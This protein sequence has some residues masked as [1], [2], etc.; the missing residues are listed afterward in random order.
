MPGCRH[1]GWLDV[2]PPDDDDGNATEGGTFTLSVSD[3]LDQLVEGLPRPEVQ[4]PSLIFL[5]GGRRKTAALQGLLHG[6]PARARRPRDADLELVLDPHSAF[7]DRPLMYVDCDHL[8]SRGWRRRPS[9]HGCHRTWE[10]R[11]LSGGVGPGSPVEPC[12]TTRLAARLVAPL[13]DVVAVFLGDFPGPECAFDR[14]LTWISCGRPSTLHRSVRPRLLLI[15][16]RAVGRGLS[17]GAILRRLSR[18]SLSSF[19]DVFS[20]VIPLTVPEDEGLGTVAK[21]LQLKDTVLNLSDQ[22]QQT[23]W[24]ARACFSARH[25][26]AFFHRNVDHCQSKPGGPFDFIHA[27][28]LHDAVPDHLAS[29]LEDFLSGFR[30]TSTVV[31]LAL[32][33]LATSLLLNHYCPETHVFDPDDVFVT[34]YSEAC[35]AALGRTA[36]RRAEGGLSPQLLLELTREKFRAVFSNWQAGGDDLNSLHRKYLRRLKGHWHAGPK[37]TTCYVC[38]FGRNPEHRLPCGHRMCGNCVR[39][40]GYRTPEDPRSHQIQLCSLC[41][42]DT[43]AATFSLPSPLQGL[44]IGSIDGGGCRGIIPLSFF[45]A[46][47]HHLGIT[48]IV[49]RAF[50]AVFGT[51]SGGIDEAGIFHQGWSIQRCQ[52]TFQAV[53]EE[54]FVRRSMARPLVMPNIQKA[55]LSCFTDTLYPAEA[56]NGALQRVFGISTG[57]DE[58]TSFASRFGIK[59]GLTAATVREPLKRLLLTN[60]NGFGRRLDG[61]GED[62]AFGVLEVLH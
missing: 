56:V 19:K 61:C 24:E 28:R 14:L 54:V 50:D 52:E 59:L 6:V 37:A 33:H 11:I 57:L 23:R 55:L 62:S 30:S 48:G 58:S 31:A 34:L 8:A 53:A 9:P 1:R 29:S 38:L 51:S 36:V 4:R 7:T 27:A 3:R 47:E 44:R 42:A 21:Y 20:D 16:D 25:L 35:R 39:N 60:Y 5:L 40:D 41:G 13:A 46:L 12:P 15:E 26:V 22:S 45:A 10:A 49:H 2:V 18:H 43:G 17:S 32:P